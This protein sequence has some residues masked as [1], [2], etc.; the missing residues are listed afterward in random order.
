MFV[1]YWFLILDEVYL[2]EKMSEKVTW[3]VYE[4]QYY[5]YIFWLFSTLNP[6]PSELIT[7]FKGEFVS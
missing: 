1:A 7:F 3:Q 2:N 6:L 4:S 5:K